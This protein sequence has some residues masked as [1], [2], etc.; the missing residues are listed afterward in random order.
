MSAY[1]KARSYSTADGFVDKGCEK[2][3]ASD[4]SSFSVQGS[5]FSRIDAPLGDLE[6]E[7]E[8]TTVTHSSADWWGPTAFSVSS[9]RHWQKGVNGIAK[10][11]KRKVFTEVGSEPGREC[12]AAIQQI[13]R[14]NPLGHRAPWTNDVVCSQTTVLLFC[15]LLSRSQILSQQPIR[16]FA[17]GPIYYLHPLQSYGTHYFKQY[18]ETST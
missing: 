10:V 13:Q 16:L 12:P 1:T 3:R 2:G 14:S 8:S 17:K 4:S 7:V 11:S 6:W 9:E 18:M 5:V 15:R